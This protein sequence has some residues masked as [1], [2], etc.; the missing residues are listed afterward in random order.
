MFQVVLTAGQLLSLVLGG[1]P[2]PGQTGLPVFTFSV[3]FLQAV[4]NSEESNAVKGHHGSG[5]AVV[6]LAP[7]NSWARGHGNT[8]TR[9]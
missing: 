4:N 1:G 2:V 6:N 8:L 3:D 5:F 9:Q 7:W